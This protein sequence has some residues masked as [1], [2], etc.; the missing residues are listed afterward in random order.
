MKE[1]KQDLCHTVYFLR[2]KATFF[3]VSSTKLKKKGFTVFGILSRKKILLLS[4]CSRILKFSMLQ[5]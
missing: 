1:T 3:F 4:D 5:Y 2:D